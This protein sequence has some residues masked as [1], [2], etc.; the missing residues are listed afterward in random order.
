M[1]LKTNK[2][3]QMALQGP[4]DDQEPESELS[5]TE[6][7]EMRQRQMMQMEEKKRKKEEEMKMKAKQEKDSGG[8]DWG[9]G[10]E[11]QPAVE[12]SS[13]QTSVEARNLNV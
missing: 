10:K 4:P 9:M 8:I 7:K 3:I 5:V 1:I 13:I 2:F 11:G 6:L 12:P